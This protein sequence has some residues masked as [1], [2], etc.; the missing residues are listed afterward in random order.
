MKIRRRRWRQRDARC[1]AAQP[2]AQVRPQVARVRERAS[3]LAGDEDEYGAQL[4][5]S[6]LRTH[7]GA[8]D[9]SSR[10]RVVV[11]RKRCAG[12]NKPRP[13]LRTLQRLLKRTFRLLVALSLSRTC[14]DLGLRACFVA[15]RLPRASRGSARACGHSG[16]QSSLASAPKG[17][18]SCLRLKERLPRCRSATLR[19]ASST[20]AL[21]VIVRSSTRQGKHGGSWL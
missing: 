6:E 11:Q 18:L 14:R 1:G 2:Q 9:A 16:V 15:R 17:A 12:P 8:N 4:C 10:A 21:L 3:D 13:S 7:R 5:T 20:A 19:A